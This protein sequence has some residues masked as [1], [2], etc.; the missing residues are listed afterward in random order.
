MQHAQP[1]PGSCQAMNASQRRDPDCRPAPAQASWRRSRRR[2]PMATRSCAGARWRLSGSC[3]S[4]S[5]PSSATL[6]RCVA[7]LLC[8]LHALVTCIARRCLHVAAAGA[9]RAAFPHALAVDIAHG[10]K[11][12]VFGDTADTVLRR[13]RGC[14]TWAAPPSA[15]SAACSRIRATKSRRCVD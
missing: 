5:P 15:A 7:G 3:S 6:R 9:A 10:W 12:L 11:V 2:W 8:E 14:G 1:A 4:T 13:R